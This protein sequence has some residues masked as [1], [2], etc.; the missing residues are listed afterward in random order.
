M[1]IEKPTGTDYLM[2]DRAL[3]A[4]REALAEGGAGVSALLVSSDK[5]IE[6]GRNSIEVTGDMTAHAEMVLLRR[7]ADRFRTMNEMHR[8][9]L[10]VYVT[11]EPCLMCAAALSLVGIKRVVYSALTEDVNAEQMIVRGLTL[12]KVNDQLLRGPFI[13][14]P[15]VRREQGQSLLAEMG[16]T[17][18]TS[19]ELKR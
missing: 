11:L 8:K 7:A 9:A 12:P 18:G 4:A 10:S 19:P 15:G 3:Q 6:V 5:V 14:V 2:M 16:K 1:P 17:A 13:L